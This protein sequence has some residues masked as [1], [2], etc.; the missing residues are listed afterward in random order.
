MGYRDEEFLSSRAN[1]LTTFLKHCRSGEGLRTTKCL[2]TVVGVKQGHA[3]CEVL[4]LQQ[5]LFYV[6][7]ASWRSL[8]CHKS[9]VNLVTCCLWDITRFQTLV[10]VAVF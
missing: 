1:F 4:S 7:C 3:T 6:S 5:S 9:E 2:R 10:Y 8:H